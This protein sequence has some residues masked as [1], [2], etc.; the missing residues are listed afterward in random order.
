V[1][2]F[3]SAVAAAALGLGLLTACGDDNG[4]GSGS[5]GSGDYC[6]DLEKAQKEL[7]SVQGGDVSS[8]EE[9]VDR[10]HQLR[11]EAPDEIKDD[12]DRLSDAFDKI[13]AAFDKAGIDEDD[14]AAIQSGQIPDGVDQAALTEAYSEIAKLG[15]DE[16]LTAS[17]AAIRKHAKDECGVNLED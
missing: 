2:R 12:W 17:V 4:G 9:T 6:K 15:E 16:E 7:N 13:V 3:L 8:L 10:V 1:K 11:D 14:I 5:A